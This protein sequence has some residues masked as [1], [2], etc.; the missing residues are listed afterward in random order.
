MNQYFDWVPNAY[1][2]AYMLIHSE[3]TSKL[4]IWDC[5]DSAPIWIASA[6]LSKLAFQKASQSQSIFEKHR[7]CDEKKHDCQLQNI[8]FADGLIP[9]RSKNVNNRPITCDRMA[10][11]CRQQNGPIPPHEESINQWLMSVGNF[12]CIRNHQMGISSC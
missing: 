6:M 11:I 2:N 9:R 3:S 1:W 5:Q 10:T 8:K 7:K 4:S 12:N